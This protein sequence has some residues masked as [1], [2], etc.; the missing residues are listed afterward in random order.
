M[1]PSEITV[2]HREVASAL[3]AAAPATADVGERV[4]QDRSSRIEHLGLR[5]PDRRRLVRAGFSFYDNSES[6]VLE[7]WDGIWR[8]AS[9]ADV[10]FAV[11]DYYRARVTT[12]LPPG[13]WPVAAS[14]IDAIDNWAHAD[15]LARLYSWAL[16]A[17]PESVYPQL[18]EWNA[19]D[20]Q[21]RRRISLVSL[22]HYTGKNAVFMPLAQVLPLVEGCLSD[23]RD[24]VQKAVG[25][26]LREMAGSY[27]AETITFIERN[28]PVM[29]RAALRRAT[30]RL[31]ADLRSRLRGA[32]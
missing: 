21:W 7:V 6:E 11:L 22:I 8:A 31:D 27:P 20:D 1:S 13:F 14:W 9:N 5:T 32:R 2:F 25:W 10:M 16:E 15:D 12:G 18:V 24:T 4:R 17:N 28:A 29:G 30:E 26:V 3:R 23:D 19:A